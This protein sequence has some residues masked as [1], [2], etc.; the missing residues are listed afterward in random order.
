MHLEW[1]GLGDG[2]LVDGDVSGGQGG[3]GLTGGCRQTK[4]VL[5]DGNA[6]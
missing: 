5:T 1:G 4:D 6:C 2:V 3:K